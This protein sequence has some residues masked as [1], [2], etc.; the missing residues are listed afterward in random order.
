MRWAAAV[1]LVALA[2]F[3]GRVADPGP[4]SAAVVARCNPA[5][6][7]V[8]HFS[9]VSPITGVNMSGVRVTNLG[10]RACVLAGSPSV[11]VSG[12]GLPAVRAIPNAYG[13]GEL[14]EGV[15]HVLSG[16]WASLLFATSHSCAPSPTTAYDRMSIHIGRRTF[17]TMIP[18]TLRFWVN[19]ACPPS[20]SRYLRGS[21]LSR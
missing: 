6:L 3:V 13:L 21:H 1:L 4:L 17:H 20:V 19:P 10:P 11:S 8:G 18:H 2:G 12:R 14:N 15:I 9:W 16:R 5:Q 7:T